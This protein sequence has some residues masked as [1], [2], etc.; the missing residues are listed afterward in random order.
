MNVR[1]F[2]PGDVTLKSLDLLKVI[3]KQNKKAA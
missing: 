1:N 3:L 2:L